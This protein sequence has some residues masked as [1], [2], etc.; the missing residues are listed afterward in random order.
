[1]RTVSHG[2]SGWYPGIKSMT[3][4]VLVFL[5]KPVL[6]MVKTRLSA[7]TGEEKALEIYLWLMGITHNAIRNL[8]AVI[9]L[10]FDNLEGILPEWVKMY[11]S[12]IQKGNDIGERMAMALK[13]RFYL[14][15]D[16]SILLI[17]S[18]CPELSRDVL[19]TAFKELKLNDIVA[20]PASDGGFYL[21]GMKKWHEGLWKS[22]SWSTEKVYPTLLNN[23]KNLNLTF[24]E[25]PMKSD[26]DTFQDFIPFQETF[27]SY[28]IGQRV[29]Q[30]TNK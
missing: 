11:N 22:V 5:R 21:V 29:A 20:G 16:S 12:Y 2:E 17:G 30:G 14:E 25:L 9:H 23:I 1:M 28:L 7:E 10:Y 24:Y 8:D 15:P 13:D 6:G 4:Q 18:D 26:I 27:E 19:E 3:R